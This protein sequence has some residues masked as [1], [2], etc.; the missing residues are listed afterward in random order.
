MLHHKR[1]I[2]IVHN[3]QVGGVEAAV[4][5]SIDELNNH[6]EFWVIS[7]HPNSE[8]FIADIKRKDRLKCFNL[9][10]PLAPI[11]LLKLYWFLR[12]KNPDL[13]ISSLW[14]SY[15]VSWIYAVC[16]RNAKV[17]PLFHSSKFFHKI[18]AF[19]SKLILMQT[20]VFWA[21]SVKSKEYISSLFPQK[22]G[23]TISFI[24]ENEG[25]IVRKDFDF[26]KQVR[27]VFVGRLSPVK[28]IDR[29]I[30]LVAKLR[31]GGINVVFDIYGPDQGY[32]VALLKKVEGANL[33]EQ[34]R[35][36]DEVASAKVKSILRLYDFLVQTSDD[37]GMAISVVQ[38]MQLGLI[39]IVTQ[40]GEMQYYVQ[41]LKNGIMISPPFDSLSQTVDTLK[42]LIVDEEAAGKMSNLAQMTFL[43]KMIY[44]DD[45][46]QH[47]EEFLENEQP[48]K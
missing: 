4:K 10:S 25:D 46:K 42:K 15:A 40:T 32:R 21:D 9:H 47:I 29:G 43:G 33:P 37:E 35:F 44:R 2:H 34:V 27:F 39:P 13:I 38:A 28:R 31:A 12:K 26:T 18:D 48:S 3:L 6:M 36:F 19:F 7:L 14:K 22:R 20:P 23:H 17:I 41:H 5:S 24:L 8:S 11:N 45:L 1:I 30:E 16:K